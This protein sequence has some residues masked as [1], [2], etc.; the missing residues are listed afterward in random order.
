MSPVEIAIVEDNQEIL[1]SLERLIA[2]TPGLRCVCTC[3][4]G[5][6]ALQTIPRHR[7]QVVIMDLQLPDI[8]GVECT[9]RLRDLAPDSQVLVYTV[10][11]DSERVFQALEAG[12]C[13]YLLKCSTTAEI[14]E[15]IMDVNHGGAPMTGEI[16]RKVVQFFRS[17]WAA[18]AQ[19]TE[20][21]SAREEEILTLLA[22]GFVTKEIA[23][24]LEISFDTVRFHLKNIYAKLHVRSRMEAVLKHLSRRDAAGRKLPP[25]R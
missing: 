7:P 20:G 12:A 23:H 9:A 16:A 17:P 3:A 13:G 11:A 6:A 25:V 18:P 15:A 14:I 5:A 19:E 24:N 1:A 2:R 21:L 8:S 10:Y 4:T 22:R